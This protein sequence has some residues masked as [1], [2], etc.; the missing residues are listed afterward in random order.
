MA[1]GTL[2]GD[3][4]YAK[5]AARS[6]INHKCHSQTSRGAPYFAH[7]AAEL[8]DTEPICFCS[9]AKQTSALGSRQAW[10][11]FCLVQGAVRAKLRVTEMG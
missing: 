1:K 6:R 3:T 5:A 8:D 9:V 10:K 2:P 4:D 7:A 11:V